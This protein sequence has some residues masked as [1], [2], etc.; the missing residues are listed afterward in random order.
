MPL[1]PL[2]KKRKKEKNKRDLSPL[3]QLRKGITGNLV[4]KPLL[5]E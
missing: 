4:R 1:E 5:Y 3:E 2:F